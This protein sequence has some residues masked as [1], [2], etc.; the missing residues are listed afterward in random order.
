MTKYCPTCQQAVPDKPPLP[1]RIRAA[2]AAAGQ[3][4]PPK[5]LR[6]ITGAGEAVMYQTLRR[7]VERGDIRKSTKPSTGTGYILASGEGIPEPD[8]GGVPHLNESITLVVGMC[9]D[10]GSMAGS[11]LRAA[12]QG[13]GHDPETAAAILAALVQSGRLIEEGGQYRAS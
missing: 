5:D 2:L 1:V 6:R 3:P 12:L 7:M 4:L 9:E 11:T 10:E 13:V 8:E